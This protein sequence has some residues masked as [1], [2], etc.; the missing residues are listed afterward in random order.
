MNRNTIIA[1]ALL[2]GLMLF[3]TSYKQK[4]ATA[5]MKQKHE[6]QQIDS[7]VQVAKN[8]GKPLA[9]GSSG[10]SEKSASTETA[11]G[12][13]TVSGTQASNSDSAKVT[14]DSTAVPH[15]FVSVETNRFKVRLDNEG[16]QIATLSLKDLA[17]KTPY[18]SQII[19]DS[20]GA[21]ALTIDNQDLSKT[22]WQMDVRDTALIVSGA[23]A[24]VTF[25]TNLPGKGTTVTRTFTFY[26]DSNKFSQHFEAS[27]N[28]SSYA[29]GWQS[30]LKETE[31]IQ[32]GKG[33]GLMSTYF[34]EVILDNGSNVQRVS[35]VGKKVFNEASGV[36]KWVGLRRKYVATLINF[37]R[38]TTNK[39]VAMGSVEGDD[40]SYPKDY[41]LQIVATNYEDKDLD[42]DFVVLPL[43]YDNLVSHHQNYEKIIFSG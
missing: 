14:Q 12:A 9:T 8:G 19:P 38:E 21:L 32:H 23:P 28:I 15:R 37:N 11:I 20:G 26:P 29:I 34:S 1:W 7:L 42:F 22:L 31:L 30:G 17:G 5:T 4:Q 40:K 41:S 39:V 27:Q 13:T 43:S 25:K 10:I 33:F 6:Q 2:M 35:F 3:W 24:T 36:L 18:N 16:A